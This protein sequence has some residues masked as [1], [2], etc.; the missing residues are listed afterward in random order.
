[1]LQ[2]SHCST[3]ARRRGS[4]LGSPPANLRRLARGELKGNCNAS[5][6]H[7]RWKRAS[8]GWRNVPHSRYD[9]FPLIGVDSGR[10]TRTSIAFLAWIAAGL[11]TFQR[12]L[13][14]FRSSGH[15]HGLWISA[16]GI[17][18]VVGCC[19]LSVGHT[20]NFGCKPS[21]AFT[22]LSTAPSTSIPVTSG[23]AA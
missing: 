4:P 23:A 18:F 11:T 7:V 12:L 14:A 13:F 21:G 8:S 10:I 15:M 19:S 22:K 1:M 5:Q 6:A 16:H 9:R 20:V 2:S 17:S 3:A